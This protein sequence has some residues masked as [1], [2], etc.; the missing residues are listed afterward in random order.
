MAVMNPVSVPCIVAVMLAA[1]GSIV[2]QSSD[3]ILYQSNA[4]GSAVVL[5]VV[6][7][8]QQSGVFGNDNELLRRIAFVETRDG[9]LPDTFREGYNGGIWAVDEAAFLGTKTNDAS[10]VRLPAKLQQIR[11]HFEIDWTS[12][13]W[14]DLRKPL[15]SAIAARLILYLAPRA[16]PPTNDLEAQAMFWVQY[17]NSDGDEADFAAISSGLEGK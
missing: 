4:N 5:L 12:V 14:S 3:D 1:V 11:D 16:I 8:L 10:N 15:H 7:R 6:G 9:T 13:Q 2:A 17:Y